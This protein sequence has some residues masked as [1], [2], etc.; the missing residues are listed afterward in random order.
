MNSWNMKSALTTN[1]FLP[2]KITS[3]FRQTIVGY[4]NPAT[5][6]PFGFFSVQASSFFEPYN[7]VNVAVGTTGANKSNIIVSNGYSA[8]FSPTGYIEVSNLYEYYKVIRARFNIKATPTN[9]ADAVFLSVSPGINQVTSTNYNSNT[10]QPYAKRCLV[11]NGAPQKTLVSNCVSKSVL[12]WS[13]VQFEGFLPALLT[14]APAAAQ[15]WFFNIAWISVSNTN[16]SGEIAFEMDI[17]QDVEIS[18]L[19]YFAL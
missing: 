13:Q 1:S 2:R 4:Y 17:V 9:V 6:Q 5:A 10:E 16:P 15:Q 3:S 14:G 12:G 11:N 8:A 7:T 19:Q 18:E